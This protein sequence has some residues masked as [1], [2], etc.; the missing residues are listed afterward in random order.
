[1]K[2]MKIALGSDERTHLT[3]FVLQKLEERGI[4]T[5]LY[6]ALAG[7]NLDWPEVAEKVAERVASARVDEGIL[8]CWTGTG[9]SIAANKVPGVRAALCPD[10]E[11]ARGARKWNHANVLVMGLRL[12]AEPVAEEIL[13]AWFDTSYPPEEA[14]TVAKVARIEAKYRRG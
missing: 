7:E 12:T 3:D 6:G 1:V 9:V 2:E 10:A 8:F 11:T 4:E 14:E 13:A 5:E